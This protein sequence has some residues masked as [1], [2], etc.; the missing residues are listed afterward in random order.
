MKTRLLFIFAFLISVSLSAQNNQ[1]ATATSAIRLFEDKDDLTSVLT[2]VPKDSTVEIVRNDGDYLLV[3]YG[4]FQ[5]YVLSNNVSLGQNI[6]TTVPAQTA[7]QQ[8]QA[9]LNRYD[10][11]IAKYGYPLG[12]L[13][14]QHKVWKGLNTEMVTDSWGQPT[15]VNRTYS[16]NNVE[17]EWIYAKK[18]LYFRNDILVN[19]GPVK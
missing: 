8:R 7:A 9:P 2:I 5:G 4:D 3:N 17:E 11:L 15:K 16:D 19:W 12:K 18:W 14:Y 10:R 13:L 1:T 6:V